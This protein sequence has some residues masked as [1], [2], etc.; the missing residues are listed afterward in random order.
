MALKRFLSVRLLLALA[1][2]A[3][4]IGAVA[5]GGASDEPAASSGD[6][7]AAST[8]PTAMPEATGE[9]MMAE[10][11]GGHVNLLVTNIGNGKFDP[12]LTEG[13]DL[14]FQ[15]IFQVAMVGGGGGS[16]LTPAVAKEWSVS[17]DG[18][19]WTF[20]V[21]DGTIMAHDGS[22]ITRDDVFFNLDS[23]MGEEAASLLAAAYYEPRDVAFAERVD[24]V[25]KGPG[26]DQV[27]VVFNTVRL[28]FAFNWSEN[29]QG[30][31]AMIVPE[32]AMRART[33][34]TGFE[35]YEDDPIGIGSMMV[36]MD[37]TIHEQRYSFEKFDDFF[38]TTTNG[39]S[40]D[41]SVTFDTLTMELVPEP[42]ARLAALRSGDAQ[43][44]EANINMIGDIEGIDGAGIAWQKESSYNWVVYVDCWD[45]SLWCFP[46]EA[47]QAAEYAINK[48]EIANGLYT[49][50]SVNMDSWSHVTPNSLGWG[51]NLR[52]RPYDVA[53]AKELL[54]SIGYGGADGSDGT[55]ANGEQISFKVYTWEAG[56]LPLLP[57]LAQLYKDFWDELGWDVEVVVGDAAATRQQ[58]NNREFPGDVLVRTNEAR[59]DGT[60]ITQGGY[61]N[62]AIAWRAVD[63]YENEPWASTTTP[64]VEQGLSD[65]NPA[66]RAA[67]YNEMYDYLQDQTYWGDGFNTNVPWG[68]GSDVASYE[69]WSLVPYVTAIWTLKLK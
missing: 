5:C 32:A 23:R 48:D 18:L 27:Q 49:P 59:F 51:E 25:L 16:E 64:I 21:N 8:A 15:R 14:K 68:L 56:D 52:P 62:P 6:G 35:G 10:S 36:N 4:L 53:K 1:L 58:W 55:D 24:Q 44:I 66:T 38:W 20:T 57:D 42:A 39:Y 30:A 9:A 40:E 3:G 22:V 47:R 12:F 69:P 2:A 33:G 34:A 61:L 17:E 46:V 50:E 11:S 67:S 13:E 29:A 65:L 19:T 7:G 26:D 54:M 31:D 60:S 28:D 45:E 43:L 63:N 37:E 41:R